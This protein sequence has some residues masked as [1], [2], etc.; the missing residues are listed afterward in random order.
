METNPNIAETRK[1]IPQDTKKEKTKPKES[2]LVKF[3]QILNAAM[4][5]GAEPDQIGHIRKMMRQ[6]TNWHPTK[7]RISKGRRRRIRKI[8][9]HSRRMNQRRQKFQKT[10]KGIVKS[11][12]V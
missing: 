8:Q 1:T 5:G 6:Y 4:E 11:G 10:T 12:R 9:K 7:K 3:K 2:L